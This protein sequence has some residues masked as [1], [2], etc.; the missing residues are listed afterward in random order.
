[1]DMV[2][3]NTSKKTICEYHKDDSTPSQDV[4]SGEIGSM[5]KN[6]ETDSYMNI[7]DND[8]HKYSI[9]VEIHDTLDAPEET[10]DS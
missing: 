8:E 3:L 5:Y 10:L 2:F 4:D 9:E 1:M 7:S 6:V